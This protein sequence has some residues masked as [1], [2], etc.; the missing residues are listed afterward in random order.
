M[1]KVPVVIECAARLVGMRTAPTINLAHG[2]TLDLFDLAAHSYISDGPY[3]DPGLCWQAYDSRLLR[4][5]VGTV[6]TS[7]RIYEL[8]GVPA[9]EGL[10]EFVSW[11]R[12][13]FI[14][15]NLTR[16]QDIFTSA[17]IALIQGQTTG[18]LDET[19]ARIH[20]LVH[21]NTGKRKPSGTAQAA[22]KIVGGRLR[23]LQTLSPITNMTKLD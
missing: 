8:K 22:A 5:V 20:D 1:T 14:G 16:T 7:E 23:R 13:P 4:Q 21:W 10:R 9:V 12:E 2:G 3:G 17:Y 18:A 15:Q 6:A 19:A 11:L